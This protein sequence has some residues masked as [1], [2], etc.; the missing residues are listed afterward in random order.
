VLVL[1]LAVAWLALQLHPVRAVV[2]QAAPLMVALLTSAQPP[3]PSVPPPQPQTQ[4]APAAPL[5]ALPVV[6]TAQAEIFTAP[7]PAADPTPHAPTTAQAPAVAQAR[8]DVPSSATSA[9]PPSPP[10]RRRL[11]AEAVAYRVPPPAELPLASRRAGET[12]V[13]WLR[14]VVDVRGWPA[15]VLVHR[16]LGHARLDEQAVSA[17]RQARFRPYVEDGVAIEVEVIAPI[18]YALE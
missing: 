6:T 11:A 9:L 3:E 2:R 13:V 7:L 16:S 12:G 18:E 14:V 1:H 4:A 17:M 15:Q 8:V 5:M 10:A